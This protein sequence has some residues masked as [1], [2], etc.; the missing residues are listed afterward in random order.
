M[1]II[2]NAIRQLWVPGINDVTGMLNKQ[3]SAWFCDEEYQIYD[4][5][6][7]NS[8]ILTTYYLKPTLNAFACDCSRMAIASFESICML[9]KN[10]K[11]PKSTAWFLLNSYYAAFFAAHSIVRM[12]GIAC[13]QIDT[14]QAR[15]I[16]KIAALFGETN[17]QKVSNGLYIC[18]FDANTNKLICNK[19]GSKDGGAHESFWVE[20]SSIIRDMSSQVLSLKGDAVDLQQVSLK[21]D[22]LYNNLTYSHCNNGSWL[23][24]VRNKI[25]YKHHLGCWY[26]YKGFISNYDLLFNQK[27]A[28]NA[29]PITIQLKAGDDLLRFLSTCNFIV[30]LCRVLVMDMA[31][32]CSMGKSFH[33]YGALAFLKYHAQKKT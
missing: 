19:T 9:R 28:W 14:P 18:K 21:L 2:A 25:N 31:N 22:E 23:S 16:Y 29:D 13:S 15:S 33:E 5:L 24:Y 3:F 27:N 1:S 30:S 4:P 7:P 26:P 17:G 12:L 32:R 10:P 8:F 11:I 6:Q 20:F